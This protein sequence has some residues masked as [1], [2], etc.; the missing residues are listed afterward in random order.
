MEIPDV[1]AF[2]LFGFVHPRPTI[3]V[4][5]GFG[6]QLHTMGAFAKYVEV[7]ESKITQI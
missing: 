4:D 5:P 6:T 2:F 1:A 3:R 7:G